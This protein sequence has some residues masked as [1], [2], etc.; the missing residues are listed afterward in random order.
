MLRT[1]ADVSAELRDRSS[2]GPR[3]IAPFSIS[4]PSWPCCTSTR[5]EPWPN[6][7]RIRPRKNAAANRAVHLANAQ[8]RR[9][10]T[11]ELEAKLHGHELATHEIRHA[12]TTVAEQLRE[13][14]GLDLAAAEEPRS[15][16]ETRQR[17]EIDAEIAELRRKI[18]HIGNVNLDA[19]AEVEELEG[20][21]AICPNSVVT[22]AGQE[23]D[24]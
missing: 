2:G 13:D 11:H 10:A 22:S 17:D 20:R 21:F 6:W 16:E 4:N 19:L 8:R 24:R 1:V 9:A 18:A 15:I 12:R 5:K 3:R 14:Y 7:P 23:V